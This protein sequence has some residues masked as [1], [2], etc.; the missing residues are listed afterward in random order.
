MILT[1]KKGIFSY[2]QVEPLNF[3][4]NETMQNVLA[5]V[6][7]NGKFSKVEIFHFFLRKHA[8]TITHHF[9]VL[10]PLQLFPFFLLVSLFKFS[11]LDKS[12]SNNHIPT[13]HPSPSS[14]SFYSLL[15]RPFG[16]T[17]LS[18]SQLLGPSVAVSV[19]YEAT[20]S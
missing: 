17:I 2:Q 14:L 12:S 18:A 1:E 7:F 3:V 9:I 8:I 6:L 5:S 15:L 20:P 16:Q 4:S 13:L 10:F 11:C 19:A